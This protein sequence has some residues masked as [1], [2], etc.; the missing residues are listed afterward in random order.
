MENISKTK[1]TVL[2]IAPQSRVSL[3][4]KLGLSEFVLMNK[5]TTFLKP[6]GVTYIVQ[7]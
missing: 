6:R 4:K 5:L 2:F 1:A 7:P 3:A